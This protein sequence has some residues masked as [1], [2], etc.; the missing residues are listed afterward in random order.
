LPKYAGLWTPYPFNSGYFMCLRLNDKL[1][2]ETF[3][4]HLL[5]KHGVGVIADGRHDVRVAFSGVEEDQLQDLYDTLAV[6]AGE[7]LQGK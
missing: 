2:A 6:A 4:R 3:R 7:L 5:D 1:D